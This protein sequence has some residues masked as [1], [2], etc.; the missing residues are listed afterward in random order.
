MMMPGELRVGNRTYVVDTI[1]VLISRSG[2]FEFM[3]PTQSGW[4]V[5]VIFKGQSFMAIYSD[6]WIE[7]Y[8]REL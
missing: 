8:T 6:H 2:S 3:A 5:Q 4:N 1:F 7:T